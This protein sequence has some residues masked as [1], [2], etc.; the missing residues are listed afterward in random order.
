ML[1]GWRMS[2]SCCRVRVLRARVQVVVVGSVE[3][4]RRVRRARHFDIILAVV[5][6]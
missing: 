3:V 2:C 6:I 4:R 5:F 1:V